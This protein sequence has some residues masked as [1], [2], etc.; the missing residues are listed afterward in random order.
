MWTVGH[1]GS[2]CFR[3]YPEIVA[4]VSQIMWQ[5]IYLFI[6]DLDKIKV[7]EKLIEVII[8]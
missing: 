1:P 8:T 3:D 5:G 7:R 4:H 2:V 6:Q